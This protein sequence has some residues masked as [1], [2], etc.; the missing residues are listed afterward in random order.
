VSPF[1]VEVL[2]R[3]A[4]EKK[5]R[6]EA[7][8]WLRNHP[9][10]WS[11]IVKQVAKKHGLK[12]SD[13]LGPARFKNIVLARNEAFYRMRTEIS[14]NGEPLSFPQI[15][16]RFHKDHSSVLHGFYKH[17]AL[18]GDADVVFHRNRKGGK[19]LLTSVCAETGGAVE[20]EQNA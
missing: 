16:K 17:A 6:E 15:A 3:R 13:L 11:S 10:H 2:A 12:S 9:P 7:I 14:V 1:A 4:A 20:R 18:I 19:K 8:E 5:A